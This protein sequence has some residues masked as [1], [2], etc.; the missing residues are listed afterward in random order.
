[1][2][3]TLKD[4][5]FLPADNILQNAKIYAELLDWVVSGLAV[6][7]TKYMSRNH[8]IRATRKTYGKKIVRGNVEITLVI[9][10]PNYAEREYIKNV[11]LFENKK[12]KFPMEGVV[13]KLYHPKKKKLQG[14]KK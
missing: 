8:I 7:V 5:V 9:G 14:R 3:K 1:M 6:R 13:V 2:K 4:K 12:A 10:K 11:I